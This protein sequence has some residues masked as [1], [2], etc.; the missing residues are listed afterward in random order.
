MS[1]FLQRAIAQIDAEDIVSIERF[2]VYLKALED[3]GDC[4]P[5]SEMTQRELVFHYIRMQAPDWPDSEAW[6]EADSAITRGMAQARA[7]MD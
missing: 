5:V 3:A 2:G 1:G 4:P 6:A 7:L